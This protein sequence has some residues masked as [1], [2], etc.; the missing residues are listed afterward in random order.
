MKQVRGQSWYKGQVVDD[1]VIPSRDAVLKTPDLPLHPTLVTRLQEMERW[2]LYA[3]QAE[4]IDA[5]LAGQNVIVSTPTASGKSLCFQAP[6]LHD[7]LQDK[8][9]RALFLYPT[10]ALAQDQM[11]AL[12]E[13]SG[14]LGPP[15]ATYDG[16]TSVEER[17]AVR[18]SVRVLVSNPDMLHSGILPNHK[19][20]E[21]FF[22]S[23]RTVVVDEAHYYR[24]VFG[25]HVAMVLRRLRRICVRYG[26]QPRFI[27][28]SATIGNPR[29]LAENLTGLSFRAVTRSGAPRGEKRFLFWNPPIQSQKKDERQILDWEPA[30]LDHSG[31]IPPQV[32]AASLLAEAVCQRI[33]TLVFVRSRTLAE[34]VTEGTK[35][36]LQGAHRSLAQKLAPYRS[37]YLP[38]DRRKTENEFK[39]GKL[40]GVVSTN[41]LELGMDIGG[42]D[43][44]VLTGYPGSLAS[45][46]QQAGRSGRRG[47][48]SLA[49]LI[50]TDD[51]LDQYLMRHPE[52]VHD[53]PM[54]HARIATE[55]PI[56]FSKHLLCAA[57]E[58]LL[59]EGDSSFFGSSLQRRIA[60]LENSGDIVNSDDGWRISP[61]MGYPAQNVNLRSSTE[62]M[63]DMVDLAS[64]RVLE[65]KMEEAYVYSNLHEGATYLHQGETYLVRELDMPSQRALVRKRTVNYYTVSRKHSDI[66]VLGN[67]KTRTTKSGA[68]ITLSWVE[69]TRRVVGY[70]RIPYRRDRRDIGKIPGDRIPL[71]LP[72]ET[73]Q[74]VA[75]RFGVPKKFAEWTSL[76]L[77]GG[78]HAM[79][80]ATIG[81]LPLFALCDR[82]D[83]GGVSTSMHRDT[84]GPTVFIFDDYPGGI[85][86]AERA[87]EIVEQLWQAALQVIAECVC[88]DGCPAC[89]QSPKC[90][91]NNEPLD[92]K[93]AARLLHGLLEVPITVE[94]PNTGLMG[95]FRRLLN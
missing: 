86:I 71:N 30:H 42:L 41:A 27:L 50:A 88:N 16:D 4:A 38:E 2:P 6:V 74:T 45:T 69:V 32:E 75:L 13:F 77:A 70:E 28:C 49:V 18:P 95:W 83:V 44:V 91:S 73:F 87:Y 33:R 7:W 68:R 1:R 8:S 25:S 56:I 11:K 12:G 79:E 82:E 48:T 60:E 40:L 20:W 10:K 3:H 34:L 67:L 92:K 93:M 26:T 85:G 46:W 37:T 81:V 47:E 53:R 52:F 57:Y 63:F 15:V 80:H 39:D 78:L 94:Q 64:G 72:P 59:V 90:D 29:E 17:R 62:Q 23:L 58:S 19:L 89:V 24:G 14:G 36:R 22:S 61:Q 84:T 35:S 66:R 9:T 5:A 21:S 55:N 76:V 51:P 43:A 65:T 54:E 31:R